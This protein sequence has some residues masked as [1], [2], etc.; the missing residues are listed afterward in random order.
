MPQY[1]TIAC[2]HLLTHAPDEVWRA[3]T[4]P[5]VVGR[6]WTAYGDLRPEVGHRFTLDIGPWG[7]Q[8]CEVTEVM[9]GELLAY[10]FGEGT[11]N[12]TL[13]WRLI[14]EGTGTRVLLEHAGWDLD[15]EMGQRGYQGM[16]GGWPHVLPRIDA[17]LAEA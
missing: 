15:T 4:D 16:G 11:V 9:P 7:L 14:A 10:T 17:A 2:D 8:E 12:T 6:W 5:E 13:T 1:G 3:L